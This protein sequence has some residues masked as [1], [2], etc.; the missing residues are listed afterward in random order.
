[1]VR[2]GAYWFG[3]AGRGKESQARSGSDGQGVESSGKFRLDK[4]W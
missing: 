3:A 2:R 4:A 1:M